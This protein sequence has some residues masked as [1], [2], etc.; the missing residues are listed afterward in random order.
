MN[1]SNTWVLLGS[2]QQQAVRVEE[3]EVYDLITSYTSPCTGHHFSMSLT[4]SGAVDDWKLN[5]ITMGYD[6]LPHV[7]DNFATFEEEGSCFHCC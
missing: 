1:E 6:H 5:L 4:L 3:G 2:R 7:K